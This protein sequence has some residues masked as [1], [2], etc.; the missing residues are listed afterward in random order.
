MKLH[1]QQFALEITQSL[2]HV[3]SK[4]TLQLTNGISNDLKKLL[5][6]FKGTTSFTLLASIELYAKFVV[7][8]STLSLFC[9]YS[10]LLN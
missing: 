4:S 5:M 6:Y 3:S 2:C 9:G 10:S 8:A 1:Y 7:A